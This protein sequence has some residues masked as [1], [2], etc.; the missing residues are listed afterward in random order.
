ML[1]SWKRIESKKVLTV[2]VLLVVVALVLVATLTPVPAIGFIMLLVG[3]G[4]LTGPVVVLG[5]VALFAGIFAL[6][7]SLDPTAFLVF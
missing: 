4:R 1:W 3:L 2:V 7:D 5:L 6:R